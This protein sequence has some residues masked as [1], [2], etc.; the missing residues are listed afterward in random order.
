MATFVAEWLQS[1]NGVIIP[2][3][4]KLSFAYYFQLLS[5]ATN[6]YGQDLEGCLPGVSD[7]TMQLRQPSSRSFSW[8]LRELG[9]R[10]LLGILVPPGELPSPAPPLP[11]DAPLP[12]LGMRLPEP[13]GVLKPRNT[14]VLA[15]AAQPALIN[16]G[17]HD[18]RKGPETVSARCW[19]HGE[20]RTLQSE[21]TTTGRAR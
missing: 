1:C 2:V 13:G 17:E 15:A 18:L 21:G 8:G 10:S 3:S 14:L 20:Q 7:A 6:M 16:E 9:G 12:S 19:L 5:Q 4:M 11:A